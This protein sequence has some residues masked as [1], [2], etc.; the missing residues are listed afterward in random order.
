MSMGFRKFCDNFILCFRVFCFLV[1]FSF[2]GQAKNIVIH[3]N[4][5]YGCCQW[6]LSH[7]SLLLSFSPL[8]LS[9]S[10][11]LLLQCR[12]R[13]FIKKEPPES[14]QSPKALVFNPFCRSDNSESLAK[15]GHRAAG[16]SE[17]K[18]EH[19]TSLSAFP[20]I[21]FPIGEF[22]IL[23]LSLTLVISSL[24]FPCFLNPSVLSCQS[25]YAI[26]LYLHFL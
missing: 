15:A 10:I 17:C 7:F 1:S 3:Y 22:S 23:N 14:P 11:S 6:V 2:S 9:L 16:T 25:V 21:I 18:S 4:F 26:L 19:V 13:K 20:S 24:P 12:R 8:L 5:A